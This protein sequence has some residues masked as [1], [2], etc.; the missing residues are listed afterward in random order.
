[1]T[2][3][4]DDGIHLTQEGNEILA[5]GFFNILSHSLAF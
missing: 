4:P 1:M 5:E 3:T 2:Y